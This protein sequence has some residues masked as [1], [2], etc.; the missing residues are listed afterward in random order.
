MQIRVEKTAG[1]LLYVLFVLL[2]MSSCHKEI[3]ADLQPTDS[4]GSTALAKVKTYT[5][6]Y[7]SG[8]THRA[9]TYELNYDASDRVLSINSTSTQG[10][11]FV[12]NYNSDNTYSMDLY[13]ANV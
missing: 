6:E 3:T 2:T 4:T 1:N 9:G 12:F 8:T 5:E 11:K 7:T 13:I 10:E